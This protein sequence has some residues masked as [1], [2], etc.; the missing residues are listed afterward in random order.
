[1]KISIITAVYNDPR[2]ERCL[3]SVASQQGNF[4]VEHIVVDS[5]STDDT[6]D[7]IEQ[8]E[9]HIDCLISEPDDGMYDAINK[10]IE[11]ATG[12]VIGLLNADDYYQDQRV[13]HDV[14][15]Q[16]AETGADACYGD[17]VYVDAD[18]DVVRYWKSDEYS[19]YK[20]YYGWM[21]PHPTF[22]VRHEIYER[23]GGFDLS[24]EISADYELMIRLLL[25]TDISVT[26]LDRVLVRM[27]LGGMSNQSIENMLTV[28]ED[29][30]R[31]WKKHNRLGRFVAP[32]LHPVE[33]VPQF[34][35]SPPGEK[36][37]T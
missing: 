18:D 10:G 6:V 36:E 27:E 21:P 16:L 33:K 19:R 28:I 29:M 4:E 30:Y 32:F 23:H 1:M 9:N 15:S 25:N 11:A 3:D 37:G 35:R 7:V 24:Y 2:V 12:D 8:Y 14:A 17:L 34:I 31:G 26:Y 20:L 5:E 22:F 13:L